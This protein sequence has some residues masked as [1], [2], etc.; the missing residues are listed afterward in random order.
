MKLKY[1]ICCPIVAAFFLAACSSIQKTTLDPVV[2][3]ENASGVNYRGS[4]PLLT[5]IEHTKLDVSFN[6]DSAYVIGKATITARPYFYPSDHVILDANGFRLNSISL[7]TQDEKKPLRYTYNGKK[8]DIQLDKIYKRDQKFVLYI[9]YV[10]MPEKLKAG[11]DIASAGDRGIY[12]INKDGKDKTK[13]RQ[14]WTQGETECNSTWFPTINGPQEKMTQDVNITVPNEYV[15]LSNGTLEYS[16]LNGNGTRTDSWRQEQPHSTY[17]TMLAVGNFAITKDTWRDKEVNYYTEPEFAP[18]AK[19]V[20]GK[21]PEMM[22]FFSEKLGVEYPW[23]KYSQIVVR[24]FV[25]GAMENTSASVFFEKMNMTAGEYL[26]ENHEDIISHELFHQWFGDLVTAESWANLPLNESFATYGEYLWDEYKYGR[27]TA[28]VKG[29]EDMMAYLAGSR[30][31]QVDLIRF[32]YSDREQMFDEVSYQKGGRILHM[33]RKVVGDEAFFKSLNLYLTSNKFQTAEVHD[34]R[35]AFEK[36]SGQ[37]LSWF[38]NQ[39]FLA[40]G[41][42]V[43]NIQTSYDQVNKQA[44][45]TIQQKQ[46]FEQTPLYRLPISIDIYSENNTERKEIVLTKQNQT[47]NFP[48][49]SAPKLINVD[50]EKYL[51]AEKSE[52]KTLQEYVFQYLH[53]PLFMDRFEAILKLENMKKEVLARQTIIKAL[54]DK[55]YVLRQLAVEFVNELEPAEKAGV[56]QQIKT[57]AVKDEVSHVR[58][59][60]VKILAKAFTAENNEDVFKLTAQDKAP[61]VVKATN[62][63]HQ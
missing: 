27:E 45:I 22:E 31:K 43:L 30:K 9:E 29:L 41:H 53:A 47:F 6:W 12:F 7:V 33:L 18:T 17:L 62:E 3:T 5:D 52:I 48:Y 50:A 32:D 24:D 51:L 4:Y 61:S 20:F 10:A 15:T 37:D 54:N 13:P 44:I 40:S 1:C 39:W 42:P 21:T 57:M 55:N 16:S 26:D 59:S 58:A 2:V 19:L 28:D 14:I 25:S 11:E 63:A 23:D 35:L 8:I 36:I 46:D 34:L 49:S 60:A 56:Y 38:F